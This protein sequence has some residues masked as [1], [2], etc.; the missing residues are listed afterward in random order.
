MTLQT[1][2][3][4][5]GEGLALTAVS[6]Q[7]LRKPTMSRIASRSSSMSSCHGGRM[8]SWQQVC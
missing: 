5:G 8:L 7:P 4:I 6:A 2:A 1:A 3:A